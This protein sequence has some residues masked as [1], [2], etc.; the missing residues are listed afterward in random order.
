MLAPANEIYAIKKKKK[1]IK[2]RVRGK[3]YW[4]HVATV[5]ASGVQMLRV[6]RGEKGSLCII[7]AL[8]WTD[9]W[10]VKLGPLQNRTDYEV[11]AAD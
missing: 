1:K 9:L 7:P 2:G 6:E 3:S 8:T 10:S 5:T 11:K 4:C